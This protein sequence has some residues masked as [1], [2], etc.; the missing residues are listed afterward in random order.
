MK[1]A[2]K[3]LLSGLVVVALVAIGGLAVHAHEGHPHGEGIHGGNRHSIAGSPEELSQRAHELGE[4]ICANIQAATN[5]PVTPIGDKAASDL[6]AMQEAYAQGQIQLHETLT[7]ASFD[8]TEFVRIQTAQAKAIKASATR[9][10]EFLADAAASMTPEQRQM[11][12][13]KAH[14]EH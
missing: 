6:G 5:C 11:F 7:A 14:A 10:M 9:Y 1:I 4:H 8:R 2:N 13:P 12:S 3:S